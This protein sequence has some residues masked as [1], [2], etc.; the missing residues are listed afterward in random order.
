MII[1]KKNSFWVYFFQLKFKFEDNL[2][3]AIDKIRLFF[4]H[5]KGLK[6]SAI[7][8]DLGCHQSTVQRWI[9]RFNQD[10]N[11]NRKNGSGRKRKLN[12]DQVKKLEKELN[13][14]GEISYKELTNKMGFNVARRT[15]NDYGIKLGFKSRRKILKPLL[16]SKHIVDRLKYAKD[17]LNKD[18]SKFVFVDESTIQLHSNF[19]SFTKR[20]NGPAFRLKNIQRSVRNGY[21]KV[22]VFGVIGPFGK[23][24]LLLV[25]HHKKTFKG[26]DYFALLETQILDPIF[27][28]MQENNFTYVQDN[29]PIHKIDEV[30]DLFD[31]IKLVVDVSTWPARSPDLNPI[32]SVW[33]L[34]KKK[35]W[36]LIGKLKRKPKNYK[37]MFNIVSKCW[38]ELDNQI[39]IKIH[40]SFEKRLI[41]CIR[42]KGNSTKY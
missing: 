16:T 27:I 1:T 5:G 3:M 34:L 37:Q 32:E 19:R 6:P 41:E 42:N 36:E 13:K 22:S 21:A 23:G 28:L 9:D 4:L 38:N 30:L 7:A 31:K 35:V 25:G 10:G 2:K 26:L 39:V 15:L 33:F 24:P 17:C 14:N 8:K 29:A 12:E 20:K 40:N 11:V 18:L